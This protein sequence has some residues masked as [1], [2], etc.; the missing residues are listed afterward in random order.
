MKYIMV[1]YAAKSLLQ[2]CTSNVFHQFKYVLLIFLMGVTLRFH[3]K[4]SH[5]SLI[6]Y[7]LSSSKVQGVQSRNT[8]FVFQSE[9][10]DTRYSIVGRKNI[11]NVDMCMSINSV[12]S[13]T[14]PLLQ[15]Y[16]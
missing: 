6:C 2:K 4:L 10:M 12:P 13:K 1:K 11:L 8:L 16:L 5:S 7:F 3:I 15:Q 9:F 14:Q